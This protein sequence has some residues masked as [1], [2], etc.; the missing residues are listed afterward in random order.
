MTTVYL[1][2]LTDA[3]KFRNDWAYHMVAFTPDNEP[4]VCGFIMGSH[5]HTRASDITNRNMKLTEVE[6]GFSPL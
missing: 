3:G 6:V 1:D 2:P 4:V 5:V